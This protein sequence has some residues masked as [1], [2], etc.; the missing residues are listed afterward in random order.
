MVLAQSQCN[1]DETRI[2][3]PLQGIRYIVSLYRK[4]L[5]D[6]DQA[7][8]PSDSAENFSERREALMSECKSMSTP[9]AISYYFPSPEQGKI[10]IIVECT[11]RKLPSI[12]FCLTYFLKIGQ[13]NYLAISMMS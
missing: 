1:G 8:I 10:H 4:H 5:A 12:I 13:V 11:G 7:N 2:H 9:T 6:S 3:H